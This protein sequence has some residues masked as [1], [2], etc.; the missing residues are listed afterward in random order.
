MF[1]GEGSDN[2][3]FAWIATEVDPPTSDLWRGVIYAT[4][5][6]LRRLYRR[7]VGRYYIMVITLETSVR[8]FAVDQS[9]SGYSTA[10][11]RWRKPAQSKIRMLLQYWWS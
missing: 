8:D 2:F 9:L 7:A 11:T 4:D 6:N 3:S 10:S 5:F 1:V